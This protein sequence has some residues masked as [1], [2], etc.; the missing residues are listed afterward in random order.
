MRLPKL[1]P[2]PAFCGLL[3]FVLIT[4]Q[5]YSLQA[6]VKVTENP[7]EKSVSIT[8]NGK[9]FT[10]YIYPEEIKKPVL[11][12]VA[13]PQGTIVTRAYPLIS[14]EGERVD[15]PH[16][17]CIWL[18]YGKGNGL[19]F[20][21]NSEAISEDKRDHNGTI[22]HRKILEVEGGEVGKLKVAADWLTP[23]QEKLLDEITTFYFS[24]KDEAYIID[25]VTTLQ[26]K[27]QPVSF[28]DNKEGM[29]AIRVTRTLEH[30][31]DKPVKLTG[32]NGNPA[33]EA[34]LD[35]EGVSGQYHSSV[36][37]SGTEVWGTRAKWVN[38][39]GKIGDEAVS[40]V[41]MDHPNNVGYPTYWHARGYGLFAAN[42]LGQKVFSEGKE[43]LNFM[44]EPQESVTFRYRIV[45]YGADEPLEEEIIESL[46]TD[47]SEAS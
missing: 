36:G 16:H 29:M 27:D 35:N 41:M 1:S 39:A 31:S 4:T 21:N 17:V 40:V 37:V 15:H 14:K 22:H 10:S 6:Q 8:I 25:R 13:T 26:A 2:E 23:D 9:L 12:P 46:F 45:I 20:W 19:D 44:L 5:L 28:D 18:N 43:E 34:I 42:P 33:D 38:L 3:V 11:F 7:A 47:F 30:P 32:A 24:Q